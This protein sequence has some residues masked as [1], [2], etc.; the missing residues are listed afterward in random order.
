VNLLLVMVAGLA[1]AFLGEGLDA[2]QIAGL[3]LVTGGTIAV[4]LAP[5]L[6]RG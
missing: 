1:W 5:R 2:R 3:A 4:Q 6:R